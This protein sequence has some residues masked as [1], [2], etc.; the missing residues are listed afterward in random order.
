MISGLCP[1]LYG[2]LYYFDMTGTSRDA[3]KT[4]EFQDGDQVTV[5]GGSLE[6][7]IVDIS[8]GVEIACHTYLGGNRYCSYCSTLRQGVHCCTL[9]LSTI[10][11]KRTT[12]YRIVTVVLAS[13][14]T[15]FRTSV[16]VAWYMYCTVHGCGKLTPMECP[17]ERAVADEDIACWQCSED[18]NQ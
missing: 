10:C 14:R 7:G 13:S 11:Q 2:C 16:M 9:R 12:A 17:S 6:I 18:A 15:R 4:V 8:P 1:A 5:V 3:P